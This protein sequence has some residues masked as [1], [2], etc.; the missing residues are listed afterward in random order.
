VKG[1]TEKHTPKGIDRDEYIAAM[2]AAIENY[3]TS[4]SELREQYTKLKKVT[5]VREMDNSDPNKA[6]LG[7][8]LWESKEDWEPPEMYWYHDAT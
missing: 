8:E 2:D 5:A 1:Y 3:G 4:E 6:K 7:M